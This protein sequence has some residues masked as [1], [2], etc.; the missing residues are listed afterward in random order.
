MPR[1]IITALCVLAG[2]IAV[3]HVATAADQ[4]PQRIPLVFRLGVWRLPAMLL[5]AAMSALLVAA[6]LANLVYQAGATA[7]Q[8]DG[9]F[10]RGWSAAKLGAILAETPARYGSELRWTLV[11][12]AAAATLALLI[13]LVLVTAAHRRS[14]GGRLAG[15]VVMMLAAGLLAIPGPLLGMAVNW[16]RPLHSAI[17]WL[18]DQTIFAPT[19]ALTLRALPVVLLICWYALGSL[20]E[21]TLDAARSEGAGFLT[22]LSRVIAPQRLPALAAA[23][24][25][26]LAIGAGDLS[27][28]ILTTPPGISTVPVLVFGMI[29]FGVTDQVA[30]VCLVFATFYLALGGLAFSLLRIAARRQTL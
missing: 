1:M 26:A 3:R 29:H 21:D 12:G 10:V 17:A 23:W 11:I 5:T 18:Y 7:R 19:L 25:A 14:P 8:A 9:Q 20:A 28:A 15:L 22:R 2:V 4:T 27:S 30:G 6:P 24:L 13:S 16:P